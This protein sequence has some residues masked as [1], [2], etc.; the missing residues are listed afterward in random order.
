MLCDNSGHWRC[1][2]NSTDSYQLDQVLNLL[3]VSLF[4]FTV[5]IRPLVSSILNCIVSTICSNAVKFTHE[6]K[7]GIK[8]YVLP[9]LPWGK[10]DGCNQKLDAEQSTSQE[11][12]VKEN[13]K[14]TSQ[15]N[16]DRKANHGHGNGSYHNHSHGDEPG[17]PNKTE[18]PRT[19][20]MDQEQSHSPET[21]VWIR[22]DVYD[23]GI[24][25][26][27]ILLYNHLDLEPITFN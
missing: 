26:P 9:T 12:G 19:G 22:C 20:D 8:L 7:V 18:A 10:E 15:T 21:T 25:I 14:P 11:N 16:C 27:G 6:G 3:K 23:T 1:S 4:F 5:V 24:G 13:N 17:T 2:K